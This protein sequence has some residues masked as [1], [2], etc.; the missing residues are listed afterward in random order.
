MESVGSI[1]REVPTESF[2]TNE[3]EDTAKSKCAGCSNAFK[4]SGR[5][6]DSDTHEH[7][8]NI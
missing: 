5:I 4:K 6:D 7:V 2:T 8:R 1:Q 3:E